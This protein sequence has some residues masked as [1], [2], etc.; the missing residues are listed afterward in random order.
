MHLQWSRLESQMHEEYRADLPGAA[1]S[2]FPE[3]LCVFFCQEALD[4]GHNPWWW[5]GPWRRWGFMRGSSPTL[6]GAMLAAEEAYARSEPPDDLATETHTVSRCANCQRPTLNDG[7]YCRKCLA[8]SPHLR[9]HDK[10]PPFAIFVQPEG[11]Q[12]L[13]V[14][15]FDRLED[16]QEVLEGSREEFE[17][18]FRELAE[19]FPKGPLTFFVREV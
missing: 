7:M 10:L 13:P 15:L 12:P 11:G 2:P 19:L 14:M 9:E 17:L 18:G 6:V 1:D 3:A 8:E 5:L 16:A 4:D